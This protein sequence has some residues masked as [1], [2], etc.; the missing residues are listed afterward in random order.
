MYEDQ[1]AIDPTHSESVVDS[2]SVVEASL[3]PSKLP[4]YNR[5]PTLKIIISVLAVVVIVV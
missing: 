4:L 3:P 5:I 2:D 1:K